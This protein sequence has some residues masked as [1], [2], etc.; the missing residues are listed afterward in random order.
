M[1]M[2]GRGHGNSYRHS[3]RR[4][5]RRDDRND[6]N[7]RTLRACIMR[8]SCPGGKI[9]C[10]GEHILHIEVLDPGRRQWLGLQLLASPGR[11]KRGGER[12]ESCRRNEHEFS[13][14]LRILA[15]FRSRGL[16]P[17]LAI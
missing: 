15:G 8:L 5:Q 13:G 6:A 10:S 9:E 4:P 3:P 16:L 11:E 17:M 14:H 2:I 12:K 7:G 1:S